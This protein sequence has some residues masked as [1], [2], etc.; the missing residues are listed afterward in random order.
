MNVEGGE[1]AYSLSVVLKPNDISHLKGLLKF[2]LLGSIQRVSH[3]VGLGLAS[4]WQYRRHRF[5]LWVRKII[6]TE[7]LY[8]R[9]L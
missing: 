5:D 2:R 1:T 6:L 8:L 3:L 4:T 7:G 9:L